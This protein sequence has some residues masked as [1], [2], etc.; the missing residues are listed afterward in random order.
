[1]QER[2]RLAG[3]LIRMPRYKINL[4]ND[5]TVPDDDGRDFAGLSEAKE[6][7]ARTGR[8]ILAEHVLLCQPINLAHRLEVVDASGSIAA[9]VY[10]RDLIEI[11]RDC[12]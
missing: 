10:F 7:A 6:E 1:L 2:L 12:N 9:I 5:L 11:K 3:G 4:F 8:E